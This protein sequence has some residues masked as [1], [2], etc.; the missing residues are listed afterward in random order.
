MTLDPGIVWGQA[1]DHAAK[2]TAHGFDVPVSDGDRIFQGLAK[3]AGLTAG[4]RDTTAWMHATDRPPVQAPAEGFVVTDRTEDR[5]APHHMRHRNG[6]DVAQRLNECSLYDPALDLA[7]ET[8]DGRVAG[9][10]LYWFDP[11][12]EV[13]LIESVR[14]EEEFQR[15][16]LARTM[17]SV[18]IHRLVTRGARRVKVSYETEAAAALYQAVGFQRTSSATW[19]RA[20]SR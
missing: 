10:S 7:V 16:G 14:V 5:D 8:V 9:Y 15:K 13:G 12:T 2:H 4:H 18:G 19:Y 17:L 3:R 1:L 20:L 6:D 11:I